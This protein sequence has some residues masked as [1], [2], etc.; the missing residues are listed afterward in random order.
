MKGIKITLMTC[1]A[2]AW[3]VL[4]VSASVSVS[5]SAAESPG[6]DVET[7]SVT[8]LSPKGG[9]IWNGRMT[10]EINVTHLDPGDIRKVEFYLD[11]RLIRER[12]SPPYRFKY[13]FGTGSGVGVLKAVV[14]G[15]NFKVLASGAVEAMKVDDAVEV[16]VN[17]VV[18]PVVVTDSKGNYV[19]GLKKEDFQVFSD[20]REQEVNFIEA[21]GAGRFN[22]VMAVDISSSMRFKIRRV[23]RVAGNFLENLMTGNDRAG[24]VFFSEEL[25]DAVGLSSDKKVLL[26]CLNLE[27]PAAGETALYDAVAHALNMVKDVRG[28]KIIVIFSDGVDNSSYIDVA[29]L[30]EKVRRSNAVIYA[31]KNLNVDQ[32]TGFHA[33]F[34]DNLSVLSGG[35]SFLLQHVSRTHKVYEK[36]RED[37]KAQYLVHFNP[38]HRNGGRKRFHDLMVKVKGENYTVRTLK[39]YHD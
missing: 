10:V 14:R 22:M 16:E 27:S 7:P 25:F 37:I 15:E 13:D 28:W 19:R 38:S 33:R 3:M 8:F 31:V 20:G 35:E 12:V 26:D 18:L 24:F 17:N 23:L 36:I 9:E 11:G 2:I 34:L 21:S 5:M 39:G 32:N 30:M 6:G 1:L 29:S 4:S